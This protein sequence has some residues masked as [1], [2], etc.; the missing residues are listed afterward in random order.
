MQVQVKETRGATPRYD[1]S[2]MLL[3]EKKSYTNTTTGSLLNCAKR[4]SKIN[5]LNWL[6][7]CYSESDYVV[8]IR[9]A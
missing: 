3:G 5:N 2:N 1:F 7:R 8:I 9:I 6:F 4:Y